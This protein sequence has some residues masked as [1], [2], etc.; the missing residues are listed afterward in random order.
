MHIYEG[1]VIYTPTM[2]R[3]VIVTMFLKNNPHVIT[4]LFRR[5]SVIMD[6]LL[7]PFQGLILLRLFHE[8]KLI[9]GKYNLSNLKTKPSQTFQPWQAL[10]APR[11]STDPAFQELPCA[12]MPLKAPEDKMKC[13]VLVGFSS[14]VRLM[15]SAS[16]HTHSPTGQH[17]KWGAPWY[18]PVFWA[19]LKLWVQRRRELISPFLTLINEINV[20]PSAF[21]K[22]LSAVSLPSPFQS[23]LG[24]HKHLHI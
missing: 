11:V 5:T 23:Y 17:F 18:I 12:H 16:T 21:V 1:M 4:I 9:Y 2:Q 14:D 22:F 19:L 13:K 3:G 6:L 8:Q 20:F 24:E 10:F 7:H 15:S